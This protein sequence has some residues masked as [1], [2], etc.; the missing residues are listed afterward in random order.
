MKKVTYEEF[1]KLVF[2][3]WDLFESIQYPAGRVKERLKKEG[4]QN[5]DEIYEE[6]K[7]KFGRSFYYTGD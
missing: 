3:D 1:K 4:V 6:F 7:K 5:A 2:Q